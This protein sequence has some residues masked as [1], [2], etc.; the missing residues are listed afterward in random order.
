[1]RVRIL[2]S[3]VLLLAV[4]VFLFGCDSGSASSDQ[5]P[6]ND[7][8]AVEGTS[9]QAN[10]DVTN[11]EPALNTQSEP[12]PVYING[13][14]RELAPATILMKQV[15]SNLRLDGAA[16]LFIKDGETL[17]ESYF[18]RYTETTTVPLISAAKWI[19]AATILRLVDE[20]F[21]SL[22][23]PVSKYL[24]YFEGE[25]GTIT[26]RQML[27]HTSGL[28][29]YHECMFLSDILLDQC[30]RSIAQ[31]ELESTPGTQFLY[32]GTAFSVA[33]RVA[34][35][36]IGDDKRWGDIFFEHFADPMDMFLTNYG[37]TRN[38][39]LSEGYVVSS[40]TEYGR[41][42]QMI[43]DGGV[44]DNKQILSEAALNEM[45]ADQTANAETGFNPR[46]GDISYGLG[47][48][49]DQVNDDGTA[50]VVSSPGGAGYMP[51]INFDRNIIGI[52]MV[53]TRNE[54]IWQSWS[55]VRQLLAEGLEKLEG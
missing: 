1:M 36:A 42:L 6:E 39:L 17:C 46:G 41:F 32:A 48:W 52:F 8:S 49:R 29:M 34:E 54:S 19:S 33:G 16:M 44:Y 27:S 21:L 11:V 26:V 30:T 9:T 12:A 7:S 50:V 31:M 38:P 55:E 23:D 25:H 43:L 35:A 20:G 13:C 10:S 28:P 3:G 45:F 14:I 37:N 47:I 22:D 53:E 4:S 2:F 40:L 15:V 5:T 18:G 24:N 51:W